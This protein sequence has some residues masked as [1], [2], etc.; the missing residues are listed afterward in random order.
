M[1]LRAHF[2]RVASGLLVMRRR[3]LEQR[4]VRIVVVQ[5]VLV[6]LGGSPERH[7]A[8]ARAVGSARSAHRRSYLYRRYKLATIGRRYINCSSEFLT[9]T[10]VRHSYN[11][12]IHCS[13]DVYYTLEDAGG[14][15]ARAWRSA[16]VPSHTLEGR[17][18]AERG[19][20]RT[21]VC[22]V[23]LGAPIIDHARRPL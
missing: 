7:D 5:R 1:Q 14:R 2:L 13:G 15:L 22:T 3:V 23:L 20:V 16:G 10:C 21:D 6:A 9:T 11:R 17:Q 4:C 12:V 18:Q 8:A 19:E